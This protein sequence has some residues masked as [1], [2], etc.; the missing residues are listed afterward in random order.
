[1]TAVD[2]L[3]FVTRR[4]GMQ[5]PRWEDRRRIVPTRCWKLLII[6]PQREERIDAPGKAEMTR[7]GHP[8][9]EAAQET[10]SKKKIFSP[11][12]AARLSLPLCTHWIFVVS[13][14]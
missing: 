6:L 8:Y 12:P 4:N 13:G 2:K 14:R 10:S 11:I 7:R 5:E 1:M 9:Q 3:L